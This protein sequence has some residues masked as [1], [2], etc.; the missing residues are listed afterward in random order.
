MNQ[1]IIASGFLFVVVLSFLI[2][3]LTKVDDDEETKKPEISAKS[4]KRIWRWV[5]VISIFAT[6]AIIITP[7]YIGKKDGVKGKKVA[8]H[9]TLT[10]T[11]KPDQ[12]GAD[13]SMRWGGPYKVLITQNSEEENGNFC[14]T[15]HGAESDANFYGKKKKG[16]VIEGW[17]EQPA[18]RSGGKWR[19]EKDPNDSNLYKGIITDPSLPEGVD[20]E[21]RIKF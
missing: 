16:G 20:T 9:A 1:F 13:P 8:I 5:I 14:F 19:L 15:L 21:L 4:Y 6:L 11:K 10:W 12:Y 7:I 2:K 3:F 18:P 17:W